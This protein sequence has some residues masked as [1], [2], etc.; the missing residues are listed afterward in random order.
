MKAGLAALAAA[1][2]AGCQSIPADA[3]SATARLQPTT[4]SNVSGAVRTRGRSA[5]AHEVT[6]ALSG[7]LMPEEKQ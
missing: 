5:P 7:F 1:A 2:L 6:A 4:G 3:P